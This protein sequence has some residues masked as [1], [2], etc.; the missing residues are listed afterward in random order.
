MGLV[1]IRNASV[2]IVEDDDQVR[3]A[4]KQILERARY[5]RVLAQKSAEEGLKQLRGVKVDAVL[6]D[7]NLP[8]ISGLDILRAIRANNKKIP[9]LM[10][11]EE[12]SKQREEEAIAAGANKFVSKPFASDQVLRAVD[13]LM[14]LRLGIQSPD[15]AI[16]DA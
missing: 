7:W 8:G 6:L 4:L 11:S 15:L 5:T 2:L 12:K 3:E 10:L 13:D 14:L 16:P 9:V 1:N